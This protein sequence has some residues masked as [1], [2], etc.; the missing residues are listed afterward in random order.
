MH[1]ASPGEGISQPN[2]PRLAQLL[3]VFLA[4][5][6]TG[7]LGLCVPLEND[8]VTLFW[9]PTG[10]ALAAFYRWSSLMWP[11]VFLA[12]L[13]IQF[14]NGVS[15][16]SSLILA[17]GGTFAPLF[18]AW[19]L[20][21]A[22]C[23]LT[24]L[25]RS[26]TLRFMLLGASGILI[27]ALSSGFTLTSDTGSFTDGLY[28]ALICWMGDSLGVFLITPF[29]ININN[30]N[31]NRVLERRLDFFTIMVIS[32]LVGLLCFPLNNFEGDIHLPI[33]FTSFVC[34]AWAALAFGLLGCAL[35]T[36]G[37]AFLA[38]WSSV[39]HLGPFSL[40]S[41]ELGYWVIWIYTVSM[42]ILGL[43]ITAAHS[44]IVTT[45]HQLVESNVVQEKQRQHLEAIVQAIPDLLFEIDRQGHVLSFN[46][47]PQHHHLTAEDLLG[48][49]L[50][51][52]LLS[53]STDAW[54]HALSEADTAGISQG[55]SVRITQGDH[56]FWYELSVAKRPGNLREDDRFIC[57][58]R[59]ITKR[60]NTHQA[61]LANEQR[62]RNIFEATRNIAVQGYNRQHEV[63]F[64][65]KAS[66]DLYGYSA[67]DAT[68]KTL[69]ELIIPE[70]MRA[71]VHQGIE[72]WHEKDVPIP[73]GELPLQNASGN[74]VWV[75]SNHV[76]IDT[77]E[78][79]EMYCLDINLE[80]Q[81][82]AL[83]QVEQE[84]AERKQV[85]E[86]L[87]QSEQR[88]ESAQLM[89]RIAYWSWNPTTDECHFNSSIMELFGLPEQFLNA[90]MTDFI[91]S[92]VH[93]DDREKLMNTLADSL[94]YHKPLTAEIRVDIEGQ[95]FWLQLQGDTLEDA[96]GTSIQGSLQDITERKGLDLA[97]TAA[98]A[99]AAS[100]PDFFVT[101]LNALTDAI[102]A[103]YAIIS[104][105]D[106][107]SPNDAVTHTFLKDGQLQ[108]NVR[109]SLE[110]TPCNDVFAESFCFVGSG[111]HA[112]YPQD[113]LLQDMNIDSYLGV[114]LRNAQGKPFGMLILLAEKPL[115]ISPQI[116]SLMFI[117]ADRISGEL[118]RAQDQEKIYNL[119]FFD[120]LTQ[121]P[122]RRML[123]D[124]LRLLTAQSARTEQHG[125]L[126]FIDI[127][128]FK[129]LNDT[130]GH[131]I[132]DQ[133]LVQV[134]ER[135][136]S[137]IRATDLAA[138]LGGD[139]FVVV[140]D[141]LGKDAE[142]AALE[143][144]KR[145]EELHDLVNLPYPLQQSVYH[146]TISIG[147][148]LFKGQTSSID[149]LLRHAD[150]AMY[151]AKDS[152]RNAIRFFDP[153]M[154]S[155]LDKRASIETDLRT[156]CE[157]RQQLIPYYQVQIDNNGKAIGAELLLR[158]RH[159]RNGMISPADFIPV[160]EQTGLIVAIGKQVIRQACE[161]LQRW[162]L[163]EEFCY[164]SIAV[165][166]SPIQ[167]NQPSFVEDVLLI[168]S[169]SNINPHLL[170]LELTESS[171]LKNVDQS[172][173]KMQ[174]LQSSGIGFSMDDFGIGY[175]S[176]SYLKRLPL[177][178][179]KIDQT[180]VRDIAID[181]NDA[182]ITRTIIA[183]AQNMNLQVIAEGVET[184]VQ[185]SFLEQNG[186]SMFQ[187]YFFGRPMPVEEFEQQLLE[188]DY[189]IG[190]N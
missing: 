22:Q 84:L 160:A 12:A 39:N 127:D 130:R 172:I 134:A 166:V 147:L 9:L 40:P 20:R 181:P 182:V 179:L 133:L 152:G 67:A 26:N 118:R 23:D 42:T 47:S 111:A 149:D 79:K 101:I 59:D 56:T 41:Q 126:L 131:H 128:H 43:M 57:L 177:Y 72:D 140:F 108:P 175:S 64:W 4:Y 125:A 141:N 98:A 162:S 173:E 78:Q 168:V 48:K 159:P 188:R 185:K 129:L 156:A 85:E 189:C 32:L 116:S 95:K 94:R 60:V 1:F 80:P 83:L 11:A 5:S 34:V 107:A 3:I 21:H 104:L 51:E 89:A 16:A 174:Q 119:A 113:A 135:I 167:F 68:G 164:L 62:F 120:P 52:T 163:R 103:H 81:R 150:V 73:S 145:A 158:W 33:V 153:H 63:I 122:N 123:Q 58:A 65:N 71:D 106:T 178:Q 35:T 155:H 6:L 49:N 100:T 165:N 87:R 18:T 24:R 154:Q 36:I 93:A 92:F 74:E 170:K 66:E 169:E 37:F 19:L 124:R 180:F 142:T 38:I 176:L 29:L 132:G 69:E 139:E 70:P 97:L 171:L 144:K 161:Q 82:K 54:M 137:I 121:L 55:K 86:A 31:L 186:C 45:T 157:S 25:N 190:V 148:N 15:L 109:Y 110:D 115:S 184:E 46:C 10:V 27:S 28:I 90:N 76:L 138:R 53:T 187:G 2:P 44:E 136:N 7:W 183:M 114:G 105:I 88:L 61:D 102:G 14:L 50:S 77:P 8:Q 75:Y 99:D 117:F 30:V 13:L 146:C 96:Q 17:T 91:T 143:A 151:Q 112:R